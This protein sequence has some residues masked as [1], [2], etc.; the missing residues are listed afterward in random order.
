MI[1]INYINTTTAYKLNDICSA[2]S[3]N[4]NKIIDIMK[5]NNINYICNS[6]QNIYITSD[7]LFELFTI[8]N[9]QPPKDSS[10]SDLKNFVNLV[11]RNALAED[12]IDR[13]NNQIILNM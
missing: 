7:D 5:K 9:R 10:L 6:S 2:F 4:Y 11:I 3:L 13:K 1:Y 8:L 12:D